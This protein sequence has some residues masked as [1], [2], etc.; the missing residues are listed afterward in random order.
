MDVVT[1]RYEGV[2]ETACRSDSSNCNLFYYPIMVVIES[3]RICTGVDYN[4]LTNQIES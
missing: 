1:M 4:V 2:T 3:F